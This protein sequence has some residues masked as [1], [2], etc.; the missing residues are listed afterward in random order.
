[1]HTSSGAIRS[2][3]PRSSCPGLP[4]RCAAPWAPVTLASG[5]I[6]HAGDLKP[7]MVVRAFDQNSGEPMVGE[8]GLHEIRWAERLAVVV[9]GQKGRPDEFSP[10]HK[11][12]APGGVWVETKDLKPGCEVLSANG[13]VTIEKV[14]PIGRGQVVQLAVKGAYTYCA[15]SVPFA[16]HIKTDIP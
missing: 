14:V 3:V 4:T 2:R 12:Y 6:C 1:M 7:G 8:V 16:S 10:H 11:F 15:G 5:L 9:A 13:P